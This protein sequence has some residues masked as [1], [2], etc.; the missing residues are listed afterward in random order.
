MA[1]FIVEDLCNVG[2]VVVDI[3]MGIGYD[4]LVCRGVNIFVGRWRDMLYMLGKMC[5]WEWV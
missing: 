1:F 5:G 2:M 3:L 4:V